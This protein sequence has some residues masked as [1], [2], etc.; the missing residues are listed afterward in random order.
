M[1]G[2]PPTLSSM[3]EEV[4]RDMPL[5]LQ[6]Q[7]EELLEEARAKGEFLDSSEAFPL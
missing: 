1:K 4:Y 3:F 2:S 6:W 7:K 5:N